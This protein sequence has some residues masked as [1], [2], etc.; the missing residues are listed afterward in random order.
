MNRLLELQTALQQQKLQQQQGDDYAGWS[1][2]LSNYSIAQNINDWQDALKLGLSVE[3]K[4]NS[5]ERL[6]NLRDKPWLLNQNQEGNC[7]MASALMAM[8]YF[9]N[10]QNGTQGKEQILIELLDAI[11]HGTDYKG[12]S[13]KANLNKDR[14]GKGIVQN[15]IE[16]RMAHYYDDD[17]KET[18]PG[19]PTDYTLIVGLMIFFKDHLRQHKSQ[20]WEKV[21]DFNNLFEGIKIDQKNKKLQ[22]LQPQ[23]VSDSGYKK[24]DLA[25]TPRALSVLCERLGIRV[26]P[27]SDL[28][29]LY[30]RKKDKL[31]LQQ[32]MSESVKKVID[33]VEQKINNEHNSFTLR[34]LSQNP[35]LGKLSG[36]QDQKISWNQPAWPRIVGIYDKDSFQKEDPNQRNQKIFDRD[37]IQSFLDDNLLMHW[38][39][40]PDADTVWTWGGK[41]NLKDANVDTEVANM[42]PVEVL[43]VSRA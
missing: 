21:K 23:E 25:L 4:L 22:S 11:Y 1:G 14:G 15:R 6:E 40:M 34:A 37:K 29:I 17:S 3:I 9:A 30:K 26:T 33:L 38:V 13:V 35:T 12:M 32:L 28:D 19:Y 8:L 20:L 5:Y 2:S 16:K 42:I 31:P 24:G 18:V 27:Y 36:F 43:V 41:H 7:G 10:R 39:F